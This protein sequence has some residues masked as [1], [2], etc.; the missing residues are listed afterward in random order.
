M[1]MK[2]YFRIILIAIVSIFVIGL[3]GCASKSKIDEYKKKGNVITVRYEAN[4]GTYLDREGITLIDMYNPANFDKD[5]SGTVHIKLLDPTSTKRESPVYITRTN[6]FLVGWYKNRELKTNSEGKPVDENGKALV[7]I[8]DSYFLEE[9]TTVA[10]TPAYNYSGYWNF[11]TD[12]IDF[13]SE[14]KEYD[15]TLYACWLNYFEF[16]YYYENNGE[17]TLFGSTTF[18]YMT[19]NKT[20][21]LTSDKDTIWIPCWVDG[22]MNYNFKYSNGSTYSFPKL[23]GYTFESAYLDSN[24]TQKITTD[25]YEH[26]GTIDFATGKAINPVQNIYVSLEEGEKYHISTAEQFVKNANLDGIYELE[27]DLD[28]TGV[29]WPATL[30]MGDFNGK[31]YGKDGASFKM[32]NITV[33]HS[34]ANA[35]NGGVFGN[36]TKN[37]SISKITFDNIVFNLEYAGSRNRDT[38]FG[39][40]AGS[41]EEGANLTEVK[42]DGTMKLGEI[43]LVDD[44]YALNLIANG[45]RT[46]VQALSKIHL[47]VYG[48]KNDTVYS[49]TINP[50]NVTIDEEGNITLVFK[51]GLKLSQESYDIQ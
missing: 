14:Q 30:S 43:S 29:N 10:S 40:F 46:N 7:Q 8:G 23:K 3:A 33:N 32:S 49:Y 36:I 42:V 25:T 45:D 34:N 21:S 12:T 41:I 4:G 5:A 38:N 19:T 47:V 51:A 2:K 22:G 6:Y 9:D 44:H 20:G 28:F 27:A 18:D 26:P 17:W 39:L 35:K 16:N 31:I 24:K 48:T 1:F 13:T 11:D 50:E 37:A 15:L